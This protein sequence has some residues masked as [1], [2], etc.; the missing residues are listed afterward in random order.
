[1]IFNKLLEKHLEITTTKQ[2]LLP[3]TLLSTLLTL[4]H[5][6]LLITYD[7]VIPLVDY[8]KGHTLSLTVGICFYTFELTGLNDLL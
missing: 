6:S 2:Q 7:K 5:L 1:M 3:G 4:T 8:K